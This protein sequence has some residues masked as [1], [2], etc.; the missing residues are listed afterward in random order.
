MIGNLQLPMN[1][2]SGSYKKLLNAYH[3]K[4]GRDEDRICTQKISGKM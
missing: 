2:D 4:M 1:Q 3:T